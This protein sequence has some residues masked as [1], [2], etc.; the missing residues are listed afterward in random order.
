MS[1]RQL[2]GFYEGMPLAPTKSGNLQDS[3]LS[4]FKEKFMEV[5]PMEVFQPPWDC[6]KAP[7]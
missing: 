3:K 2:Q 6:Y 4:P 7:H 1:L 5:F